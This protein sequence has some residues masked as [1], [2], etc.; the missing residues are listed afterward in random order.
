MMTR[1]RGL[2]RRKRCGRLL[3][4]QLK[5]GRNCLNSPS[6]GVIDHPSLIVF[7]LEQTHNGKVEKELRELMELEVTISINAK[8]MEEKKQTFTQLRKKVK[9]ATKEIEKANLIMESAGE[10]SSL[11]N[12][13]T[14]SKFVRDNKRLEEKWVKNRAKKLAIE[15]CITQLKHAC[16]NNLITLEDLMSKA[17]PLYSKQFKYIHAMNRIE[18]LMCTKHS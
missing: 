8:I 4:T 5:G 2:C 7:A 10:C 18:L 6:K 11:V 3:K 17:R 16:E 14:I 12:E 9:N 13:K 1:L 15:E